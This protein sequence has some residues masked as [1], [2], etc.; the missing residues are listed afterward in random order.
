MLESVIILNIANQ[1]LFRKDID[2]FFVVSED[3]VK[4]TG[5][6]NIFELDGRTYIFIEK[7]ELKFYF[8]STKESPLVLKTCLEIF[9]QILAYL[10]FDFTEEKTY[11]NIA[12]IHY[13]L[14]YMFPS[15]KIAEMDVINV[16]NEY[17]DLLKAFKKTKI[18]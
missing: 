14:N 11:L 13:I 18:Q 17:R 2:E 3:I 12:D 9:I 7:N 5:P 4:L 16:Q 10:K 8:I 6:R 1:T 15:G